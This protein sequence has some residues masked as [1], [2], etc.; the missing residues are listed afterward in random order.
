MCAVL[1]TRIVPSVAPSEL[2]PAQVAREFRRLIQDG[3]KLRPAGEARRRPS[4]LLSRGYTPRHKIEL[5]D[6]RFYLT[7]VRQDSNIRFFVAYVVPALPRR[8]RLEIHP[9]IFYKDVSLQW[10]A[11]SHF[12]RA[13]GE[14]WIGK[15]DVRT[16]VKHGYEVTSSAE[17]TT[18]LPLEMQTAL[19]ILIR[20]VAS[21]RTDARGVALVLR[22]APRHR[23]EAYRDFTEPRRRAQADPRNL[24]HGGRSIA[25]F[26]RKHDPT[27]L[28]FV[29]GYDPDFEAGILEVASSRSRL[30]GGEVERF[31]ILSK[32]RKIQYLFLAAPRHAWIVPPQATTTELSSYGVRT[33]DVVADEDLFVP[34]Y[35]YHYV[36][37]D[38]D[39]PVLVSQIPTG[40]VGAT[41]ELDAT[42]A[43]ASAWL[44]RVPVIEEFR[45]RVVAPRARASQR[46]SACS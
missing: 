9:R 14:N 24:I 34:G 12:I 20:R 17:E 22:R 42:R 36:D 46:R 23:I 8:G 37:T 16:V 7:D 40:F 29:A 4:Q 18:D 3:A 30:Y 27:S 45:R 32:N 39:P 15:G 5:F 11:A 33:V 44:D 21:V 28:R 38:E 6:T 19:E 26:T 13:E 1:T 41:S 10:R 43:D 2:R 35:E 31:R 25:R